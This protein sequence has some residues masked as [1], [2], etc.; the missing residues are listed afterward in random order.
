[1]VRESV[2]LDQRC[3]YVLSL[4]SNWC[5][6]VFEPFSQTVHPHARQAVVS[7]RSGYTP[8]WHPKTNE[9]TFT[10]GCAL[11]ITNYALTE[12]VQGHTHR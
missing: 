12:L 11:Q 1:M 8:P 3:R 10:C 9:A 2:T 6:L 7:P 4:Y 5:L